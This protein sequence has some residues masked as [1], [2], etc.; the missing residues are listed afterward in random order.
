MWWGWTY[1]FADAGYAEFEAG[2]V[3]FALYERRRA[4]WLTGRE[5]SPGRGWGDRGD[6]G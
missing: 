2:G 6:G 5:V 4:E 3:R 1:K